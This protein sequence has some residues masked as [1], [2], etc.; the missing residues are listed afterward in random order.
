M[1]CSYAPA[2][3]YTVTVTDG[4]GGTASDSMTL[5]AR[6]ADADAFWLRRPAGETLGTSSPYTIKWAVQYHSG[7]NVPRARVSRRR[8]V[9]DRHSGLH[10]PAAHRD[11]V[12]LEHAG[13]GDR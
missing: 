6:N 9:V 2:G 8:E 4:H 12:H 3:T 7:S 10:Q 1:F 13:A 5:Y 11:A